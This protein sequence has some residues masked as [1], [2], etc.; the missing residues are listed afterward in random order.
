MVLSGTI[1]G[2]SRRVAQINGRPYHQGDV[3]R[4]LHDGS[5][6]EFMLAA[7]HP[8]RIVLQRDDE[9]FELAIPV[10]AASGRIE[11]SAQRD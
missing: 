6:I 2:P 3:V 5:P 4:L 1:I 10:P 9:Q 8:Q 7:V 11:L